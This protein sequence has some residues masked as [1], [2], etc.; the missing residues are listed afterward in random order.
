MREVENAVIPS[1]F[2][3]NSTAKCKWSGAKAE[4]QTGVS[5]SQSIYK[6]LEVFLVCRA[7]TITV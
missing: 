6:A 3:T 1:F 4:T 7:V 5:L 2:L